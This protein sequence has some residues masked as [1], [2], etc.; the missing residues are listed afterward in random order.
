MLGRQ[1]GNGVQG[2]IGIGDIVIDLVFILETAEDLI[3]LINGRFRNFNGLKAPGEGTV[4]VKVFPVFFIGRRADTAHLARG[5][6]RFQDVGCIQR[7][8]GYSS[9]PDN[10]VNLVDKENNILYFFKVCND[11]FQPVFEITTEAGSSQQRPHVQRINLCIF[12]GFRNL[13]LGDSLGEPLRDRRFSH[14]GLADMNGIILVAAA[15]DLDGPLDDVLAAD[16]WVQFTLAGLLHQFG[17]EGGQC[18]AGLVGFA[19]FFFSLASFFACGF[20]GYYGDAVSNIVQEINPGDAL[21]VEEKGRMGF[22]LIID[23]NKEIAD[24]QFFLL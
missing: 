16:Q 22:P 13:P 4:L 8:A 17:R 15:E 10:G 9:G 2:F 24:I 19:F 12:Q 6:R 14:A 3:S 21:T 7:T 20:I 11:L 5:K 18:L 23:G 1:I